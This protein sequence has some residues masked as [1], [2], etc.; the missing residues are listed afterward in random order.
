MSDKGTLVITGGSGGIGLATAARFAAGGWRIVN[1]SR[2][3]LPPEHLPQGCELHDMRVDLALADWDGQCGDELRRAAGDGRMALVHNAGLLRKDSVAQL[4]RD[5]LLQ[6][7]QVGLIAAQQLNRLLL[8]QMAAGSA[9]VYVGSTLGTK[10]VAGAASYC[11]CKHAMVGLMRATCQDLAGRAIHSVC[12][13]PGFTDTAMLRAHLGG[14]EQVLAQVAA[15][16]AFAR[17]IDPAEIATAI[18]QAA[19]MPVLNGALIHANLGQL[20]R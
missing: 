13:C 17:L 5:A 9:I 2:S 15:G 8:P 6:V 16:N 7:L 1:L 12:L 3:P 4:G 19:A 14:D 18:W 10:A 11:I 20:E